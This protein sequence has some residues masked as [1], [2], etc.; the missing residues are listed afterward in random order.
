MKVSASQPIILIDKNDHEVMHSLE[1]INSHLDY[2]MK[3]LNQV[4][5][6]NVL[7]LNQKRPSTTRHKNMQFR[8]ES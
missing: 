2:L 8:T 3:P 4:V 7:Q 5:D 6:Q 1:Q